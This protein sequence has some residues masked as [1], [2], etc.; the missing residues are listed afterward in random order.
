MNEQPITA[1]DSCANCAFAQLA[2]EPNPDGIVICR[3]SPP[4]GNLQWP[5]SIITAW[6]GEHRRKP[7][8]DA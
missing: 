4:T 2:D 8:D 1:P 6:C 7:G 3:R 5:L